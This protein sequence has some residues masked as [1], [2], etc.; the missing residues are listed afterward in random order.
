MPWKLLPDLQ[1]FPKPPGPPPTAPSAEDPASL[2]QGNRRP[3]G[4]A[5]GRPPNPLPVLAP[6]T[7][8]PRTLARV[9]GFSL[10]SSPS[11]QTSTKQVCET[12]ES[13]PN[14]GVSPPQAPLA[15]LGP[16]APPPPPA[17]SVRSDLA[18]SSCSPRPHPLSLRHR[19]IALTISAPLP[20]GLAPFCR[21][22]P[23]PSR[24]RRPSVHPRQ[25]LVEQLNNL[26]MRR[27]LQS[28]SSAQ[29]P[30]GA[31][32]PPS[33]FLVFSFQPGGPLCSVAAP[34]PR[35]PPTCSRAP[36]TTPSLL[37]HHPPGPE[38]WSALRHQTNPKQPPLR[39]S[40]T[41]P[42]KPLPFPLSLLH[43]FCSLEPERSLYST[44]LKLSLAPMESHLPGS[45]STKA[46]RQ[47]Q[48]DF[49]RPGPGPAW[50]RGTGI[51]AAKALWGARRPQ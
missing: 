5:R 36:G 2:H 39:S 40:A 10:T 29:A 49:N 22:D 28:L 25:M 33:L 35:L 38:H 41:P 30:L 11:P 15:P 34:G 31:P 3:E 8:S 46:A 27:G 21:S 12:G 4:G 19:P 16:P 26:V 24:L 42:L 13:F 6:P 32:R 23:Q 17:S 7:F 43:L 45:A 37:S 44:H 14:T 47:S 20:G 50:G 51:G 18:G 1:Q 9:S 48:G